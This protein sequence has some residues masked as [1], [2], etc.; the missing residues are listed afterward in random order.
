M[1]PHAPP[2][3]PARGS[4]PSGPGHHRLYYRIERTERPE[5]E[6][7]SRFRSLR[8][9]LENSILGTTRWTV[10]T[11]GYDLATEVGPARLAPLLEISHGRIAKVGGGL[12]DVDALYGQ[13]HFWSL[14]AGLRLGLGAPL[15]RMG[16]YGA[17]DEPG[18][19]DQHHRMPGME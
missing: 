14:T 7:V 3:R 1:E 8:P 5:E 11:L 18:G 15:H 16:R 4:P 19:D 12:F 6:R 13:S 17:V 10:Q 2:S 9:H